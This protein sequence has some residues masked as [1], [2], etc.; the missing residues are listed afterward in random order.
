MTRSMG[1]GIMALFGAPLAHEDHAVRACMAGLAMQEAVA[2]LGDPAL[3]IRVGVHSGQ[4]I[5]QSISNDLAVNYEAVGE[6]V[7]LAARMEQLCEPGCVR[8]SGATERLVRGFV[9]LRPLG[10]IAVKGLSRPIEIYEI[11]WL[12]AP[13]T[14]WQVR[15]SQRLTKFVGRTDEVRSLQ[16]IFGSHTARQR[17]SRGGSRRCGCGQIK[18]GARVP[19]LHTGERCAGRRGGGIARN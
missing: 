17:S 11:D 5:F 15:A 16:S 10:P 7:H 9:D 4:V 2:Q 3:T 14:R 13:R 12:P 19:L 8:C 1:D 6:A 18:A